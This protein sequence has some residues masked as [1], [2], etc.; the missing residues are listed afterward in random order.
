MDL[1]KL[2][3]LVGD[4][5]DNLHQELKSQ[6]EKPIYFTF[7]WI[8]SDTGNS[9]IMTEA[10]ILYSFDKDKLKEEIQKI[11]VEGKRKIQII[12]FSNDI[13]QKTEPKIYN[14]NEHDID[15]STQKGPLISMINRKI[16]AVPLETEEDKNELKEREEYKAI[17]N[18]LIKNKTGSDHKKIRKMFTNGKTKIKNRPF[19]MSEKIE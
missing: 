2:V 15:I 6:I 14:T 4:Y 16:E 5:E 9:K 8:T 18:E 19:F 3:G 11:I 1:S 17:V 10:N 7:V 13:H 12:R